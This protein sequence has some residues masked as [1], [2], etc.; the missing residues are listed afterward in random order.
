[1]NHLKIIFALLIFACFNCH[2]ENITLSSDTQDHVLLSI[3]DKL[4]RQYLLQTILVSGLGSNSI[5]LDRGQ[6]GNS[7]LITFKKQNKN[8]LIIQQQSNFISHSTN[9]W[10]QKRLKQA[11][12][13]SVIASLPIESHTKHRYTVNIQPLIKLDLHGIKDQLKQND[14]SD[15]TL[16]NDLSFIQADQ[17]NS[18]GNNA[19]IQ[20]IQTFTI[21]KA[22]DALSTISPSE[23]QVSLDLRI[24]LAT[25]SKTPPQALPA[26]PLAGHFALQKIDPT[27]SFD[28]NNIQNLAVHHQLS[29]SHPLTYYIEP[30]L[31]EDIK[32]AILKGA[33]WW[34]QAFEQAGWPNGFIVKELPDNENP[35]DLKFNIIQWVHRMDRGWSYGA[36]LTDPRNAVILKGHVVLGALRVRQDYALLSALAG[37]PD[38]P[39]I[40]DDIKKTTLDRLSQLAAHEVG[41]TLG[42]AHNFAASSYDRASVMDY[43]FPVIKLKKDGKLDFSNSYTQQIGD[44]DKAAIS[45]LYGKTRT[46]RDKALIQL[47]SMSFLSDS[48]SRGSSSA[49]PGASLWD[50]GQDSISEL[51]HILKL[52]ANALSLLADHQKPASR[53][54][55]FEQAITLAAFSFRYQFQAAAKNLGGYHLSH[56]LTKPGMV[57]IPWT[58]QQKFINSALRLLN[59]KNLSIPDGLLNKTH[60]P[61]VYSQRDKE[62]ISAVNKPIFSHNQLIASQAALISKELLNPARLNRLIE[63]KQGPEHVREFLSKLRIATLEFYNHSSTLMTAHQL[64][65]NKQILSGWILLIKNPDTSAAVVDIA[66]QQ[67][68][69]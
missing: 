2:A 39:E 14:A 57:K 53:N 7:R 6:M 4:D 42:L 50:N 3:P 25:L 47:K 45:Y 59:A 33:N 10:Q 69:E 41:H 22:G 40:V 19:V 16:N 1:M 64:S 20:G 62:F 37:L 13:Y 65:I 54:L 58:T 61:D 60:I 44:W 17:S 15:V 18:F 68:S 32:Q 8:L 67:L 9:P 51:D 55:E 49:D 34:K 27:T 48:D 66:R 12:A 46:I 63:S 28:Q 38:D 30:G 36:V 31:P 21:N 35:L 52:R 43:P 56:D 5:G 23:H 26:D 29:E 24:V 11:F